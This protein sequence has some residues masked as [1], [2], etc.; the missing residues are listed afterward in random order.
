MLLTCCHSVIYEEK[1]GKEPAYNAESPDE[2]ALIQ[3]LKD[4]GFEFKG[5]DEN[6]CILI[7]NHF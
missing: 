5:V 2:L 4:Y 7:S 6:D 3:T 1:E